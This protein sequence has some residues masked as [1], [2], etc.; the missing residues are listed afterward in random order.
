[1]NHLMSAICVAVFIGIAQSSAAEDFPS[2][3]IAARIEAIPIET[4]TISDQQFLQG[5]VHG[6]PTTI[7][8]ALRIAQGAGRLPVVIFIAGSGGFNANIDVWDRQFLDMGIST[9]SMDVF[10]G[11]GITSVVP[12]QSQLGRLNAI[13]DLY[14]TIAILAVHPRVDPTRIAVMGFS[15]GGQSA[16]YSS[17]KR[18]QKLWN[19]TAFEPA[20]YLALYP[21]CTTTFLDDTEVSDHPIRIFHGVPDDY[22]EIGPCCSY[23][24]RLQQT[25]KDVKM[26][27]FPILS[28]PMIIRS[29]LQLRLLYKMG[30]RFTVR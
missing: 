14:R 8:G 18:F 16:L 3:N 11:R 5:D 10:A 4:L 23:F 24:N 21:Q 9:F 20:A 15:R 28:T 7:A 22:N 2:K 26:I 12:D 30:K 1:M 17:M 25:A 6:K 19:S 27:E 13:L 29:S